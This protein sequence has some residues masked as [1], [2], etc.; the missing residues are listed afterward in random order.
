MFQIWGVIKQQKCYKTLFLIVR[1]KKVLSL[2]LV[3]RITLMMG[4]GKAV[5]TVTNAD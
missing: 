5:R 3:Q 1:K 4:L 2:L